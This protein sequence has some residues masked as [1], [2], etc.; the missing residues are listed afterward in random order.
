MN[1]LCVE[2][3]NN[4][5]AKKIFLKKSWLTLTLTQEPDLYDESAES[6]RH[7]LRD[8]RRRLRQVRLRKG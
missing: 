4:A 5:L 8:Q 6:S 7:R 2:R 1:C 3:R